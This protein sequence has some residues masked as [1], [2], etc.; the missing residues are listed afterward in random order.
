ML[1]DSSSQTV[2]FNLDHFVENKPRISVLTSM[3]LSTD[4]T[5]TLCCTP[6]LL[7]FVQ[8]MPLGKAGLP[9]TARGIIPLSE[10]LASI[11]SRHGPLKH[12]I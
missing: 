6:Q 8:Q 3:R 5:T 11:E 4:F 10:E 2:N 7:G 12:D 9:N 1:K